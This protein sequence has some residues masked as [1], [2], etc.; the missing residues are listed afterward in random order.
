MNKFKEIM[1]TWFAVLGILAIVGS[2]GAVETD[3]WMLAFTLFVI[4]TGTMF[5]SIVCQEKQ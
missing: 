4:G 1:A 2:A 5:I 3:Q